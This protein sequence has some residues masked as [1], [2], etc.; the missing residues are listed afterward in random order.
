[1]I[2]LVAII[3]IPICTFD[4]RLRP[5]DHVNFRHCSIPT[6]EKTHGKYG[7]HL[8]EHLYNSTSKLKGEIWMLMSPYRWPSCIV[9]IRLLFMIIGVYWCGQS[10]LNTSLL[11]Q[12]NSP[13]QGAILSGSRGNKDAFRMLFKP[14][15][16][17]TTRSSPTPN[18]PCGGAPYL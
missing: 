17:I 10:L 5:S 14:Q 4:R 11:F 3:I 1:M 13:H 9:P 12:R 15:K 8:A 7:K 18:P 6:R 16:S 2:N